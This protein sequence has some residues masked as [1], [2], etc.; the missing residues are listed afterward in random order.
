MRCRTY[1]CQSSGSSALLLLIFLPRLPG[2]ATRLS[3][4][5]LAPAAL[6]MPPRLS[7]WPLWT[8]LMPLALL[9]G[10]PGSSR[11][12]LRTLLLLLAGLGF[13]SFPGA[14]AE[15]PVDSE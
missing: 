1:G 3:L 12:L 9:L 8:F 13:K 6:L 5:T 10:A 2:L 14:R 7:V 11:K 4:L 15:Q